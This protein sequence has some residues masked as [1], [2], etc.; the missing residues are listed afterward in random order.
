M[1]SIGMMIVLC[2]VIYNMMSSSYNAVELAAA[3]YDTR[4][5]VADA[6]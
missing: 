5:M 3:H 1:K 6:R 4:I 2:S